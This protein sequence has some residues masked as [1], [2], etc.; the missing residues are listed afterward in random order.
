V[1]ESCTMLWAFNISGGGIGDGDAVLLLLL[2]PP[3]LVALVRA[4]SAPLVPNGSLVP[5]AAFTWRDNDRTGR[6][7]GGGFRTAKQ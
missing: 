2:P 3:L 4:R 5:N 7:V 1:F 6:N